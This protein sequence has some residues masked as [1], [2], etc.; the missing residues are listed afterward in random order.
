[1]ESDPTRICEL[2]VGLPEVN[3]LSIDDVA[4]VRSEFTSRTVEATRV[5]GLRSL[6]PGEGPGGGRAGG[7]ALLRPSLPLDLAQAPVALSRVI[8]RDDLLD[9]QGAPHRRPAH[10]HE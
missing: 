9:R 10:G 2:L 7:S 5:C 6:R 3:V 4:G 1:M 8:V